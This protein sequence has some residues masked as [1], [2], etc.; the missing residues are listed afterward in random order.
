L[1]FSSWYRYLKLRAD[2]ETGG[3]MVV[4]DDCIILTTAAEINY[5][6]LLL[7]IKQVH[8]LLFQVHV[9]K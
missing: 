8:S 3:V 1:V 9:A 6:Y 2:G 7:N 5:L 4:N